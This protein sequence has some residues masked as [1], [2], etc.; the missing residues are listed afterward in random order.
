[1]QFPKLFMS[2]ISADSVILLWGIIVSKHYQ[3]T[4]QKNMYAYLHS[5]NDKYFFM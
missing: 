3:M 1:M 2:F 4:E 5:H